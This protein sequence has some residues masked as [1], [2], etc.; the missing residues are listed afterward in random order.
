MLTLEQMLDVAE[1]GA[2]THY[3]RGVKELAPMCMMFRADDSYVIMPL[4]GF[5]SGEI[6]KAIAVRTLRREMRERNAVAYIMVQEAWSSPSI[7][8][9]S[10]EPFPTAR[11]TDAADREEILW[12]FARNKIEGALRQFRI[13]RDAKGHMR[14]LE[15]REGAPG[16][17]GRFERLLDDETTH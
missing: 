10:G 6:G 15:R 4:S 2:R 14:E 11:P 12:L 9:R 8:W 16:M 1:S 3:G 13:H 5:P 17:I 7:T